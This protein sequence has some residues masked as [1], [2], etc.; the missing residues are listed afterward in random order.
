MSRDQHHGESLSEIELRALRRIARVLFWLL[1][2]PA[3]LGLLELA[4]RLG[5]LHEDALRPLLYHFSASPDVHMLAEDP[6]ELFHLRPSVST[7]VPHKRLRR[8]LTFTHNSLGFRG[9]AAHAEKTPGVLR[10]IAVGASNLYGAE[11][12]DDETLTV[13]LERILNR[14]FQ[15]RFEVWNGGVQAQSLQQVCARG[16]RVVRAYAPDLLLVQHAH[17]MKRSF[18]LDQPVVHF[19]HS[20]PTLYRENLRFLPLAH[21]RW[22]PSLMSH[23]ALYATVVT[24]LNYWDGVP[25]SAPTYP[26]PPQLNIDAFL[27]LYDAHHERTPMV[28][29]PHLPDFEETKRLRQERD[30]REIPIIDVVDRALLEQGLR[31]EFF[32]THPPPHVYEAN[33]HVVARELMR[34]FPR[35][36]RPQ[37]SFAVPPLATFGSKVKDH[38]RR[39]WLLFDHILSAY[40]RWGK[41]EALL[42]MLAV[43]ARAEPNNAIYPF[44][45]AQC[46]ALLGRADRAQ[47]Y[48]AR[49]RALNPGPEFQR[50]I[51]R[52]RGISSPVE[53]PPGPDPPPPGAER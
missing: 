18:L 33:A 14:R 13:Y 28:L 43:R 3:V 20:D 32:E 9:K 12:S 36:F 35:L 19:F 39:D 7:Q 15:G 31:P 29:L 4:V 21:S 5:G 25:R 42:R 23:W 45:Q 47:V 26:S 6:R 22:G 30:W 1:S 44:Y 46:A 52:S 41:T 53:S 38:F 50:A 8:S 27:R 17:N 11:V 2:V 24:V 16:E 40:R 51:R 34:L 48:L 37:G 10:V 49:A